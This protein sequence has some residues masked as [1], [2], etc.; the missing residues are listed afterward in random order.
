MIAPAKP[1][2]SLPLPSDKLPKPAFEVASVKPAGPPPQGIGKPG[3]LQRGRGNGE[4]RDTLARLSPGPPPR[5]E[6]LR[7]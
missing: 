1:R 7:S 6:M 2:S 5:H 4:Y 3:L